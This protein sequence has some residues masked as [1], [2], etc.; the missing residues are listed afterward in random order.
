[1]DFS[2]G[3]AE[4]IDF[5]VERYSEIEDKR[6]QLFDML[7]KEADDHSIVCF[8]LNV[9]LFLLFYINIYFLSFDFNSIFLKLCSI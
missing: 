2:G 5:S 6:S 9:S 3:V 7:H 4:N 8:T 1:M